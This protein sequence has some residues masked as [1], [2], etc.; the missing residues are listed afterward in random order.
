[1]QNHFAPGMRVEIRDAEWRLR[2]VER[3]SDGGYLLACEGLSELVRG[4][5]GR[6]LTKLEGDI[7][8][9]DPKH[10][11]LVDDTTSGY[12]ASLLYLD[13]SIRKTPASG[14]RISL[15]HRAALDPM[16]FQLDP[17]IQALEQP[18]SR[19]L[20]ADAVGLGKTLE[21][22]I[23]VSE[24]IA[25]GRG[26]RI[27]VLA[28]KSMLSQ[29]QQEFWNR[30]TIPLV[31]LDSLGL[32]RVRNRIPGNHN[33]FHYFDRT[34]ISIDTLK[35][36]I[37]YR[38]YLERAYWDI[39]IIDE[40]HNVAERGT[41]SQRA[42][43]AKLLATRSDTLIMLSATPH[44]GK[45]RS[46]ASLMNMLDPT[47]IA[48][49]DNYAH[50][51]FRDKGLVIRRF[52][53]DVADQLGQY[54][55]ERDIDIVRTAAS[56]AEEEAYALLEDLSF[57]TLDGRK[58]GGGGQLFRTSLKKALY[59]SPA[60]CLS[61]VENRMRRL[62][63]KD[64]TPE[65][66]E[67]LD[68]LQGLR[69]A[70]AAIKPAAFSKYQ[71]LLSLLGNGAEGLGWNPA[72]PE[73][74]LVIFTESLR[75]LDF[76]HDHLPKALKLK[77]DQVAVLRGEDP[78]HKLT[79]VVEAFGRK[80]SPVRLL[81]CSDVAAEGINLHHLSHRLIHFDVPWS[82]MVFQQRNGRIDRYGQTR[83]PQIR[84]LVTES[85]NPRVRDEQRV[86]EVLIEKDQQAQRNIGDPS[87][88]LGVYSVEQEEE[89][90]ADF[91]EREA[92]DL[93]ALFAQFLDTQH[94]ASTSPLENFL[95]SRAPS[96]S[97][98]E[99]A[100]TRFSLFE[101]DF[102]YAA[103]A[104]AW[105]RDN[106]VPLQSQVDK[107]ARRL[108]LTAPPDLVQRLRHL[109]PESRPADDRFILTTDVAQIQEELRRRRDEDSPWAQRQYLWPL[110]PVMEWLADR[111]L[112]AF[113]RHTAPVVRLPGRLAPDETAFLLHGGYPNQRGYLLIQSWLGVL[114]RDGKVVEEMPLAP[115]FER[116][117]L[118][119]G[120]V[121]N[122][123]VAGD[124]SGLQE[125]LPQV[126]DLA[127]QRLHEHKLR[128]EAVLNDRLNV[129]MAAM[130]ALKLRHVEQLE[131]DLEASAQA[132]A[133][134]TRRRD[135]RMSHIERI[136]KDYE[137]WLEQTQM[138]EQQPYVQ[139]V[140]AF[141]GQEA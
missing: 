56:T 116:L 117:G 126:V 115:F 55:H 128:E 140:A 10:T 5:E 58:G 108:T 21:A 65:I 11:Q 26:Q 75:T 87:E 64:P 50:E 32:Q 13:T 28:V 30:F 20:I 59:S 71:R 97:M 132:D 122:R 3:S 49:P 110:H 8:I 94:E 131:L 68:K 54:L 134:K 70:L 34:I 25:R 109:P 100:E 35:Q 119:P 112:N 95:P 106:S 7:R 73:D 114:L 77:A 62:E 31:R 101:D 42:R 38:H 66:A 36:D 6:F 138:I 137:N 103:A 104:L 47:A 105:L 125:Q 57:R 1:M 33:P 89:K 99:I 52:K 53:K 51:N 111:A 14:T 81:L 90:V 69:L 127:Y 118:Q 93:A 120:Q 83:Q 19:I 78:D 44:D 41:H 141:T 124:T 133:I 136:F 17:A 113:G 85:A 46:F 24:L 67:D 61:T 84:Y 39:I 45:A 102:A 27:L 4:R 123:G 139:V 96:E 82:L 9:L 12:Q 98:A 91:I 72:D 129:Q 18:R 40:A 48:N 60:A 80:D 79:A 63:K 16:P 37:E 92:D 76:L 29:F 2:F 23:L 43:L 88:F 135:E 130:D 121:P 15:G 86:L 74:R 107:A 22:G